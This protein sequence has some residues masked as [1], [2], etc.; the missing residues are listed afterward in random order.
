MKELAKYSGVIVMLIGVL[1]LAIPFLTSTTN[2]ANLLIGLLL[3]I[4]G[5]LGHI[6]VNNMKQGS[7]ASN[8]IWAIGLLIIPFFLFTAMKKVGYDKEELSLYN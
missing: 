5:F 8:I 4:E 3:V 1:V 2:N 7:I 6:Y